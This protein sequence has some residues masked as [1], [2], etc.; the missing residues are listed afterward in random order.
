[1]V[2]SSVNSVQCLCKGLY[3]IWDERL[4]VLSRSMKCV[5]YDGRVATAEVSSG[6]LHGV[7]TG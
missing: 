6:Q 4:C 1:M 7:G 2:Y 3:A 5:N